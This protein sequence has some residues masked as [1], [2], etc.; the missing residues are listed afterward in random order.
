LL[1]ESSWFYYLEESPGSTRVDAGPNSLDLIET[2][3]VGEAPGIIGQ[4]ATFPGASGNRLSH[5]FASQY[6]LSGDFTFTGWFNLFNNLTTGIIQYIG[7]LGTSAADNIVTIQYQSSSDIIEVILSDGVVAS[8]LFDDIG[9]GG[10]PAS[11]FIFYVVRWTAATQTMEL[12]LNGQ[13]FVSSAFG[14]SP[15]NP[16]TQSYV[17]G[18]TNGVGLNFEGGIDEVGGW[19]RK[20]TDSEVDSL[21]NSGAGRRPSQGAARPEFIGPTETNVLNDDNDP[22]LNDDNDNVL[23]LL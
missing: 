8:N 13:A 6:I 20:L 23:V 18:E 11:Q 1:L 21:Y 14:R 16:G 7:T 2:G 5:S 3:A 12:R 17:I 10:I 15:A 22:V 9:G 19:P 4:G